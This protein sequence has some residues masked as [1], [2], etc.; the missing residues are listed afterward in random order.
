MRGFDPPTPRPPDAD[1]NRTALP[2]EFAA[3][4]IINFNFRAIGFCVFQNKNKM[5]LIYSF[6]RVIKLFNYFCNHRNTT[7]HDI[8]R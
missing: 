2:A 3:A 4:K 5:P 1:C 8:R 7:K 6:I